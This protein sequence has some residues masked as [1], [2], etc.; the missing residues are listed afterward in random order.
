MTYVPPMTRTDKI[1][2]TTPEMALMPTPKME[3][4]TGMGSSK[5]LNQSKKCRMPLTT[6]I[7]P[8]A[9]KSHNSHFC[10]LASSMSSS[11]GSSGWLLKRQNVTQ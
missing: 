10:A 2:P 1:V 7:Q 8:I 6:M 5:R 9:R 3:P 4:S 11:S